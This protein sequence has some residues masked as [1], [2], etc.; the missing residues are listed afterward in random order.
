MQYESYL[1]IY[2]FIQVAV[3]TQTSTYHVFCW[4]NILL[5]VAGGSLCG[6]Q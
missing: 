1:K 5:L 6:K 3:K 4:C 2:I